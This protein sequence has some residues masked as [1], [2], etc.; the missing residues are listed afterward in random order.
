MTAG[1]SRRARIRS[2]AAWRTPANIGSPFFTSAKRPARRPALCRC[3]M[4]RLEV[5]ERETQTDGEPAIGFLSREPPLALITG[6]GMTTP[7]GA[8]ARQT[9]EQLCSGSFIRD[10]ARIECDPTSTQ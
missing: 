6:W 10:P 9:W 1:E 3:D 5:L 8:T 4:S 2:S 7:L